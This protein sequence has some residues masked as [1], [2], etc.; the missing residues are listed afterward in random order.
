[1]TVILPLGTV[2]LAKKEEMCLPKAALSLHH[3]LGSWPPIV[4]AMIIS[5]GFLSLFFSLFYFIYL[6]LESGEGREKESLRNIF[7]KEK[8]EAVGS[9]LNRDQTHNPGM[10]CDWGLNLWPFA[11][12]DDTQPSEPHGS[13]MDSSFLSGMEW[14]GNLRS[15]GSLGWLGND[16]RNDKECRNQCG[17]LCARTVD[18]RAGQRQQMQEIISCSKHRIGCIALGP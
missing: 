7:V 14:R 10:C 6:F 2:P 5:A 18:P 1:M 13:G 17:V 9:C 4:K 11:L 16:T 8:H 12:Q 3:I 15:S